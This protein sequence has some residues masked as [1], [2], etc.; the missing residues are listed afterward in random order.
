MSTLSHPIAITDIETSGLDARIHEIL[1]LAVIVVDPHT[2]EPLTTYSTKIR[3]TRIERGAKKALEVCGY[4]PAS[5]R[6][7][8]NLRT[9]ME[10]YAE[11]CKGAI[12]AGHNV[13]FTWSFIAEAFQ[14]SGIE[15]PTDY[16]R[17][18]L[19][20]VAWAHQN[21]LNR[22][23]ATMR[24]EDIA[25][26]LDIDPEPKPHRA[27]QGAKLQLAILQKLMRP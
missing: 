25:K 1:E 11:A 21:I 18:D 4:A 20:S 5:W 8:V 6:Y 14:Q 15:D 23:R 3:P 26:A 27:M 22:P 2:L 17:L 12:F 19:F 16:H 7:A 24:L 9:A 13:F 10:N